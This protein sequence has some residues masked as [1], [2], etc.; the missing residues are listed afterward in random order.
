[1]LPFIYSVTEKEYRDQQS[2]RKGEQEKA[3]R[4]GEPVPLDLPAPDVLRD[5]AWYEKQKA[6]LNRLSAEKAFSSQK[7]IE[8][9][10]RILAWMLENWQVENGGRVDG[11]HAL[12]SVLELAEKFGFTK[13]TVTQKEDEYMKN[14]SDR[15]GMKVLSPSR[16][17]TI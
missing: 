13:K 14:L 16:T 8:Y 1:L 9:R 2:I 15:A 4:C 7:N 17:M 3:R 11:I 12:F 5:A 10:S 6:L